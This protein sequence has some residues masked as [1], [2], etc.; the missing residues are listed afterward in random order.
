MNHVVP[1]ALAILFATG[2]DTALYAYAVRERPREF[3]LCGR[4]APTRSERRDAA[5]FEQHGIFASAMLVNGAAF[6]CIG[7]T[8]VRRRRNKERLGGDEE[9]AARMTA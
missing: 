7:A 1:I 4:C 2:L 9:A 3:Y 8:L 6:A 5:L